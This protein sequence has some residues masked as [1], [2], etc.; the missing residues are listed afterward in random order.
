M[1]HGVMG[2][3]SAVKQRAK[4]FRQELEYMRKQLR[5]AKME[6]AAR[7]LSSHNRRD[8]ATKKILKHEVRAWDVG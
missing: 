2:G 6:S 1:S 3:V 5:Q 7:K 4:T 8:S